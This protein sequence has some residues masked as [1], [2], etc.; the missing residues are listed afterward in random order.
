MLASLLNRT[1]A[2]GGSE[3]WLYF[4]EKETKGRMEKRKKGYSTPTIDLYPQQNRYTSIYDIL[5]ITWYRIRIIRPII[6]H[7]ITLINVS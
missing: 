7:F 3:Y 2:F 6:Q 4:R 5:I 1:T